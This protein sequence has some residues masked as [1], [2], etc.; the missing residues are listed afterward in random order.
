MTAQLHKLLVRQLRRAYGSPEAAPAGMETLLA[1]VSQAYADAD[2]DRTMIER[3]L[4]LMSQELTQRNAQLQA[5]LE[6]RQRAREALELKSAEQQALI[7]RLEEAHNQLLQSEKMASIGQLAAGVAHE[8]NNPIGFVASNLSTMQ[9]YAQTVVALVD[10]LAALAPLEA[11]G[12]LE[13]H[14]WEYLREDM[15]ALL[16]ESG[17]GIR[18]V[19]QIV[20]DLKDFSHVDERAWQY[21]DLHKGLDS[22]LNIVANEVKY[23]ADV[24]RQ[25]GELPEVECHASQLNQVF[26]NVLVNAAHAIKG[27]PRGRIVVRTSQPDADHVLIE[28]RDNGSG[29][30]PQ[31]LPRIFDPFF[32]TKPVGSGTGLGLSLSWGIVRDHGGRIDVESQVGEGT[33]FRIVLPVQ[34]LAGEAKPDVA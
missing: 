17:D 5:E 2:A 10:G 34:R 1:V 30:A 27:G 28:F 19:K 4:E 25:Y 12:L 24:E 9:Q 16:D 33:T 31:H 32:T 6:E 7:A 15:P 18:R 29:I 13:E 14:E 26:M 21:A 11:G 8:I 20:Q 22:T 3:S 23:V